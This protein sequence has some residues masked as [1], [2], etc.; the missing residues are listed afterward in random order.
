M[1]RPR[2]ASRQ[3]FI[4]HSRPPTHPTARSSSPKRP[5]LHRLRSFPLLRDR[6]MSGYPVI[7]VGTAARG[8]GSAGNGWFGPGMAPSGSTDTGQGADTD[9]FGLEVTGDNCLKPEAI[10]SYHVK[11]P[12]HPY[13][14][15]WT[16]C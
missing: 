13:L 8:F 1:C 2:K 5:R 10:R 7:G 4:K 15:K 11:T 3:R 12:S 9:R 16:I 6:T 14:G